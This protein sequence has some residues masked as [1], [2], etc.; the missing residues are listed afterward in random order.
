MIAADAACE[1]LSVGAR[2]ALC[3]AV[4]VAPGALVRWRMTVDGASSGL[5][6]VLSVQWSSG[7]GGAASAADGAVVQPPVRAGVD[8]GSARAPDG[9][10]ALV[11]R[12]DNT[13]SLLRSKTVTLRVAVGP[14]GGAPPAYLAANDTDAA[15]AEGILDPSL[16]SALVMAGI[17]MFFNNR[18]DAAE[19]YFGTLA[20]VSPVFSLCHSTLS[21][22]RALLTWEQEKIATA[23][24]RLAATQ[25]LCR[26]FMP[27]EASVLAGLSAALLG[28][29]GGNG[30]GGAV[31]IITPSQ[32]DATIVCGEATLL[33][34]LLHLTDESLLGIVRFAMSVRSGWRLLEQCDKMLALVAPSAADAGAAAAAAA[35]AAAFEGG[36]APFD[37][38]G[39]ACAAFPRLNRHM[40]GGVLFGVGAFNCVASVLPPVAVRVLAA[41]GFPCDREGGFAMLR[42]SLRA[43]NLRSPLSAFALMLMRVLMPSFASSDITHNFAEAEAVAAEV[44]RAY[45][46]SALFLWLTGRLARLRGEGARAAAC[47][48][49]SAGVEWVQLSHLCSYELAWSHAFAGDWAAARAPFAMLRANNEWSKAFYGYNHKP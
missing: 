49:R 18:L 10:A 34:A 37:E 1:I 5:D 45:P 42:R 39:S 43:W 15:R 23:H 24:E 29:G 9:A 14:A 48:Q 22:L 33:S 44:A 30:G 3:H 32:L 46:D 13:G 47:L 38:A 31:A 20:D 12:L 21:F 40:L 28:G 6:V 8:A 17:D 7:A 11:F 36:S 2:S 4:P 25:K 26:T 35:A 41:L 19:A 16:S 27:P